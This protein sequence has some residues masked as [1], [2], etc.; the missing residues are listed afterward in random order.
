MKAM[1]KQNIIRAIEHAHG[2]ISGKGGAAEMLGM[3]S[4]TLSSR[5][6]ALNIPLPPS[7]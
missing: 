3:K 2:K 1:E 4:T 7:R 5:I 6:K